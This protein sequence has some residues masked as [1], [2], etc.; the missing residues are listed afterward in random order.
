MVLPAYYV[1]VPLSTSVAE[2]GPRARAQLVAGMSDGIHQ[3]A[4][5]IRFPIQKCVC[6]CVCVCV[7]V[8]SSWLVKSAIHGKLWPRLLVGG[9]AQWLG[10]RSLSGGLS[11]IYT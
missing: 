1:S 10:R 3:P 8:Q 2:L 5:T 6:V 9:V 11:L 7:R 4:E